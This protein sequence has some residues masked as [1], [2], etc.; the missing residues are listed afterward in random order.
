MRL[1]KWAFRSRVPT[2]GVFR[3]HKRFPPFGTGLMEPTVNLVKQL[4]FPLAMITS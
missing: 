3:A 4:S 2:Q 1:R